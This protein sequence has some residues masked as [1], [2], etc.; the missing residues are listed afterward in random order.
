MLDQLITELGHHDPA[1]RYEAAHKLGASNDR[2]AVDPLIRVLPDTNAKVQYAAFSGLIKLGASHAAEPMVSMLVSDWRSRV[3][4]LIKLN[5]GLR[6]RAG[7]LDL[8]Q[9]GDVSIADQLVTALDSRTPDESQRAFL[10]RLLGRTGDPARVE[11]LINALI[12]ETEAVQGA[13]A[14]ALGWMGD[15]RAVAPLLVFL[16]DERDTLRETAAE[17]LGRIGDASAVDPLMGA[18]ADAN[19]WVRRA[20]AEALGNLGDRRAIEPLAD[21]LQDEVVMVQDAAFE[22]LQKLSYG[23]IDTTF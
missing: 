3:W 12:N 2:R 8:V 19:E 10:I 1:I 20:A 23:K 18:L 5:V 6:L 13:A 21:R 9:P 22:A 17:A 16:R 4:E 11:L 14:E 15:R 7:L